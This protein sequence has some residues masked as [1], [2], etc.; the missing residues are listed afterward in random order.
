MTIE[1][2]ADFEQQR[3][4]D[5][6]GVITNVGQLGSFQPR[7]PNPDGSMRAAKDKRSLQ[8]ADES[9]MS[10]QLTLWGSVARMGGLQEGRVLAI[11]GAR[12]TDYGGKNLNADDDHSQ[13]FL[14]IDHK[15]T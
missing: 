4:V 5:V 11:K 2:I 7:Q 13:L 15:R 12:V 10:V 14:D 3:T 8:L 6:V 9:G 1:E